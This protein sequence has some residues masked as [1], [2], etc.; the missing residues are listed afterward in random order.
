MAKRLIVK[1]GDAALTRKCRP[2]TSFD[3][4]L[5]RLL[6]DMAE[7]MYSAQG[8]G[9]AAPQVAISRRLFVVDVDAE[10]KGLIEFINPE[11]L[12]MSGE[13][14]AFEGCLSCP[15]DDGYVV[16]AM[17]VKIK[18]QDRLG[19]EFT[20]DAEG[21][22]AR[23]IQHEYDHLDGILFIDRATEPPPEALEDGEEPEAE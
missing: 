21:Y 3:P 4:R 8:V 18:A 10:K 12:E 17:K 23:A 14:G 5:H 9:I 13:Q 11:I 1:R 6:D 20:L 15:D 7:T 16:R 2:I 22:L 19:K